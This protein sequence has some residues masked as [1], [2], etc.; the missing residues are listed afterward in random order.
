VEGDQVKGTW[1]EAEVVGTFKDGKLELAFSFTPPEIGQ[2]GTMKIVGKLD[3]ETLS[4]NWEF[5]PY[6]G[7]FKATRNKS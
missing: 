2:K 7:T 4:G 1:A 5:E 3:G 6:S